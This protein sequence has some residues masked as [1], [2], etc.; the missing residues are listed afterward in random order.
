MFSSF[1][2]IKEY[3]YLIKEFQFSVFSVEEKTPGEKE[4]GKSKYFSRQLT[5]N[6]L[7]YSR[8]KPNRGC[9][10]RTQLAR[11]LASYVLFSD[12][13]ESED[14]LFSFSVQSVGLQKKEKSKICEIKFVSH[15]NKERKKKKKKNRRENYIYLYLFRRLANCC[16]H[17]PFHQPS[18]MKSKVHKQKKETQQDKIQNNTLHSTQPSNVTLP[19]MQQR[20]YPK[21]AFPAKPIHV[22]YLCLCVNTLLVRKQRVIH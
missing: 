12:L 3:Q 11:Q 10:E 6:G 13:L 21:T 16:M 2:K 18:L 4:T 17:L 9:F 1:D 20:S 15:K 7:F 19:C 22:N 5:G 8:K 14:M